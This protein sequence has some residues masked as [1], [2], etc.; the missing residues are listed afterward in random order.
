M[1]GIEKFLLDPSVVSHCADGEFEKRFLCL[2]RISLCVV[3]ELTYIHLYA[4]LKAE[5]AF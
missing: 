3:N 5:E 4:I 2:L 1:S